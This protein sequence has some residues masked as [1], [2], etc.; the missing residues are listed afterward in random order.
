M[1]RRLPLQGFLLTA[2]PRPTAEPFDKLRTSGRGVHI[3][4]GEAVEPS[5]TKATIPA[6]QLASALTWSMNRCT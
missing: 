6:S 2:T 1:E 3:A 4:R 5:F